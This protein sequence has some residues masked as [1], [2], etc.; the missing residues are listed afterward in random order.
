MKFKS[1]KT[2]GVDRYFQCLSQCIAFA[3]EETLTGPLVNMVNILL[4]QHNCSYNL[5]FRL[6]IA[7]KGS[8]VDR[9]IVVN[10]LL[11]GHF[12]ENDY[13]QLNQCYSKFKFISFHPTW[14]IIIQT[15]NF[16]RD[17]L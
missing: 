4:T 8:N 7:R 14:P 3:Q 10:P 16:Q 5:Y 11:N 9:M 2:G 13:F 6:K 17:H 15:C 12:P 1:F